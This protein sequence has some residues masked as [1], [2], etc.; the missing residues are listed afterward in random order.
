MDNRAAVPKMAHAE[1]VMMYPEEFCR[2][3]ESFF[4]GQTSE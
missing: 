3:A 1:P 4:P 2:E